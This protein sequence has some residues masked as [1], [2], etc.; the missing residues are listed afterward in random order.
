MKR[1]NLVR[2]LVS[3]LTLI[4]MLCPMMGFAHAEESGLTVIDSME[5]KYASGFSVDYCEGGYKIITDGVGKEFLWVPEGA[6]VPETDMIVLQAPLTELGCFSTTHAVPLKAL[7]KL[8]L[9]T[10][11]T[12]KHGSWHMPQIQE[13]MDAGTT[14]YVGKSKEPDFELISAIRPQLTFVTANTSSGSDEVLMKFDEL[15]IEWMAYLGNEESHP[16]GRIE[17][18]K[19]VG[20]LLDMEEEANTFFADAEARVEAVVAKVGDSEN[21]PTI[22]Q[23]FVFDGVVYVRNDADYVN[24]M[25][26]MAGGV[27]I[28][29]GLAPE[30]TGNTKVTVEE[31]YAQAQ[32]LDVLVYDTTSDVNADTI[33]DIVAY[34]EYLADMKAIK[35]GN[36]WGIAA[37]YWQSADDVATMIE[38]LY[39]IMYAPEEAIDLNYFYKLEP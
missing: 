23:T 15:G 18:V 26:A 31:Y 32:N 9:V 20:A 22:N 10:M 3:L 30:K 37:N 5:L 28:F 6:E 38:E 19:L 36:V 16:L 27:N 13:Q 8:D 35:E 14:T 4:A 2:T 29:E 7:G 39:T 1:N 33:S 21:K 25:L 24:K 11:V 34:G 12:T 17:W